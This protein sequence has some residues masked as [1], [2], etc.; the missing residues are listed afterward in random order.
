MR[1]QSVAL[2]D[3]R[4]GP[5]AL[6]ASAAV[7]S[8]TA[9][10]K[11]RTWRGP[12]DR[13]RRC[14]AGTSRQSVSF[15]PCSRAAMTSAEP[16][17][18]PSQ[19]TESRFVRT[20][21][22]SR[23]PRSSAPGSRS[24]APPRGWVVHGSVGRHRDGRRVPQARPPRSAQV[25][26]GW[27]L[28]APDKKFVTSVG[29]PRRLFRRLGTSS[30]RSGQAQRPPRTRS[31]ISRTQTCVRAPRRRRPRPPVHHLHGK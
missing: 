31:S 13:L 29:A 30:R 17:P 27:G 24:R 21:G 15:A 1:N 2:W 28:Q 20:S 4:L 16:C 26:G 22:R 19:D 5:R 9:M 18:R 11:G 23:K 8:R 25:R 7:S 14:P 10:R 3:A 12:S 6:D